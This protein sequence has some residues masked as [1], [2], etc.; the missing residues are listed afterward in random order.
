MIF[1]AHCHIGR[2]HSK[3]RSFALSAD[4]LVNIMDRNGIDKAI[5]CSMGKG[6]NVETSRANDEISS[7]VRKH[8]DRLVGFAGVNPWYEDAAR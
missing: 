1:D 5:V 8:P 6:L 2:E 7:A 4:E 3:S